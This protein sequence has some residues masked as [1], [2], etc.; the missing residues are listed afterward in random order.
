M[1]HWLL[2]CPIPALA[3]SLLLRGPW[4]TRYWFLSPE[5]SLNRRAIIGSLWL[6]T[7]QFVHERSG[8]PPPSLAPP[9]SNPTPLSQ[10][11]HLLALRAVSLTP[12]F[13]RPNHL[14]SHLVSPQPTSCSFLSFYFPTLTLEREGL[15]HFYG[16]A[17]ALRTA[18]LANAVIGVFPTRSPVIKQLFHFQHTFPQPPNCTLE[19]KPC[20]CGHIHGYLT[21]LLPLPKDAPLHI[22]DPPILTSP[23]LFFYL[24][25]VPFVN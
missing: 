25:G 11:P 2:F 6:A 14:P 24:M 4:K 21:A 12:T 19:F 16:P 17:P 10:L 15:P 8:L 20:S 22:G 18:C 3:G 1:Q 7:R 13:F 9:P 5:A 23:I